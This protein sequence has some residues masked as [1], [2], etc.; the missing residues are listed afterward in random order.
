MIGHSALFIQDQLKRAKEYELRYNNARRKAEIDLDDWPPINQYRSNIFNFTVGSVCF[1]LSV[2]VIT[3]WI[4]AYL[5]VRNTRQS[6][7]QTINVPT[8]KGL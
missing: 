4:G 1:A 6:A 5:H 3:I 8:N 2:A 7:P